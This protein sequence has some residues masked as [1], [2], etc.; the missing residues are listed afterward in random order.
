[1]VLLLSVTAMI[2]LAVV[3][4]IILT[5]LSWHLLMAVAFKNKSSNSKIQA[6]AIVLKLQETG[7]YINERPQVKVQMQVQPE[8]GRNFVAEV[9][10]LISMDDLQLIR[11]GSRI[12]VQYNP[13]NR[14]EI[15]LVSAA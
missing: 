11:G 10:Q 7:L 1:M 15:S 14:K 2:A 6:E 4:G 9:Q 5:A 13:A 3:T 8:R 12:I